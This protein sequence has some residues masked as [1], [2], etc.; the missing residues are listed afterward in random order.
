[1][2]LR[3]WIYV[4]LRYLDGIHAPLT[5]V[6]QVKFCLYMLRKTEAAICS[7]RVLRIGAIGPFPLSAFDEDALY[8]IGWWI[9]CCPWICC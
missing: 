1:M 6:A 4:F 3:S 8:S 5:S 2:S 7:G 9:N